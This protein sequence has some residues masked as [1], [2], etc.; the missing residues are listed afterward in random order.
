MAKRRGGRPTKF[1]PQLGAEV[2][3]ALQVG[4]LLQDAAQFAGVH[5]DTLGSWV[6]QGARKPHPHPLREFSDAFSKGRMS[7]KFR[8]LARIHAGMAKD[9]KAA[10]WWLGVTDPKN[11]GPK[12]RVTLE[13]EF[14][15][16][17]ARIAK[18]LPEDVYELVLDA[19]LEEDSC[20]GEVS[21]SSGAT[22]FEQ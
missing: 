14:S 1:T 3:K 11:Y 5:R 19:I 17:L 7:G 20:E 21:P 2:L 16:A 15:D 13:Q 12:V 18:R 8:A 9:W 6:R 10:A 22:P 4:M